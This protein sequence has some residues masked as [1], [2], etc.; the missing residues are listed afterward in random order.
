MFDVLLEV[1]QELYLYKDGAQEQRYL[2]GNRAMKGVQVYL[3]AQIS[4]SICI[5]TFCFGCTFVFK[6]LS[7]L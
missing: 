5:S 3:K 7:R 1:S 6:T 4:V 2:S